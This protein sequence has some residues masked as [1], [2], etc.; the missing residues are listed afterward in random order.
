MA[1]DSL[2]PIYIQHNHT[3]GSQTDLTNKI[4]IQTYTL[5]WLLP[6][7]LILSHAQQS[8]A[9][10]AEA[11]RR[12]N[13]LKS[14]WAVQ[15]FAE[16]TS[17]NGSPAFESDKHF[18]PQTQ[19]DREDWRQGSTATDL[20]AYPER[21]GGSMVVTPG[22][23]LHTHIDELR[24]KNRYSH[25]A[26]TPQS[27]TKR[28]FFTPQLHGQKVE[29]IQ[30]LCFFFTIQTF[31]SSV[32]TLWVADLDVEFISLQ[33][34][35]HQTGGE[36]NVPLLSSHTPSQQLGAGKPVLQSVVRPTKTSTDSLIL[37]SIPSFRE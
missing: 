8:L 14:L 25:Y 6:F 13:Y 9:H 7:N 36:V 22:Q 27:F 33:Q 12:G 4:G 37:S 29:K 30:L 3:T 32:Y 2:F 28:I 5:P 16:T 35:L 26:R 17:M 1:P 20:L 24:S 34:F 10:Y 15:N 21:A 18:L 19:H 31:P 23:H 11:K